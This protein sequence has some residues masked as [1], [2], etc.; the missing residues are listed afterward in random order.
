MK[1]ATILYYLF[2]RN[3]VAR[4]A[5]ELM[6]NA[7]RL[8]QKMEGDLVAVVE[9]KASERH[10][11]FVLVIGIDITLVN[12]QSPYFEPYLG[13]TVPHL[14]VLRAVTRDA[15]LSVTLGRGFGCFRFIDNF[16]DVLKVIEG[17]E[18]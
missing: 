17:I 8:I 10:Q 3:G 14:G 9:K 13:R 11:A 2:S 7:A 18:I 16:E 12:Q 1:F 5:M 15:V 6:P 4:K